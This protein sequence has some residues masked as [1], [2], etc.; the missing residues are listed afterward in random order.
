MTGTP[1]WPG[2]LPWQPIGMVKPPFFGE[3]LMCSGAVET[4][5]HSEADIPHERLVVGGSQ[6]VT[7]PTLHDAQQERPSRQQVHLRTRERWHESS[8]GLKQ[9]TTTVSSTRRLPR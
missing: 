4:G 1:N 6:Q 9:G 2:R 7:S 8:P 5:F 3:A